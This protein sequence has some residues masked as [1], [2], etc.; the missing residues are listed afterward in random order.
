V[1][2]WVSRY[3]RRRQSGKRTTV[4]AQNQK[5]LSPYS[6]LPI[7]HPD[8]QV[9]L[10]RAGL[11]QEEWDP[12]PGQLSTLHIPPIP[13][14][15]PST[16]TGEQASRQRCPRDRCF[17]SFQ[18]EASHPPCA[19]EKRPMH[20]NGWVVGSGSSAM[21]RRTGQPGSDRLQRH[22]GHG[23]HRLQ[24]GRPRP[25]HFGVICVVGGTGLGSAPGG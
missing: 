18:K 25:D 19:A 10:G 5:P 20:S 22:P 11:V 8:H 4:K 15:R 2:L 16:P 23:P 24:E 21:V 7:H 12:H 13:C 9:A 3:G 1:Y 14:I 6:P 17:R